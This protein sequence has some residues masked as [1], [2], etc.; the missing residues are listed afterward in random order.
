L[1]LWLLLLFSLGGYFPGE[2][3]L[4]HKSSDGDV[5]MLAILLEVSTVDEL[6]PYNNTFLDRLWKTGGS[7]VAAGVT[8]HVDHQAHPLNPYDEFL[9]GNPAH[10]VYDGS[11]T[12][13]P[14]TEHVKWLVFA[15]PV[16]IS[17]TDYA[18]LKQAIGAGENFVGNEHGNTNRY[19]TQD[20]HGRHVYLYTD[21]TDEA[22]ARLATIGSGS[23]DPEAE[24]DSVESISIAAIALAAI[25][26]ICTVGSLTVVCS[27]KS[28][29]DHVTARAIPK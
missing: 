4:K 14:C 12:T 1:T 15:N 9:P 6:H 10:F 28:T 25:S 7:N 13:P 11:L 17:T 2:V 24:V 8:T 23:D 16:R 20:L 3:Q 5:L 21:N 29:L 26:L 22:E 19:P 18:L 27:L